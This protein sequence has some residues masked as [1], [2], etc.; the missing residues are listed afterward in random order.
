MRFDFEYKFHSAGQGLFSS[1]A[2]RERGA[3][4]P[5]QWVFDCGSTAAKSLLKPVV[6]DFKEQIENRIDLLCISHFD[7]D[8]VSGLSYLLPGIDVGTL[9]LPNVSRIERM[10]LGARAR[11]R[12]SDRPGRD[13]LE[14]LKDPAGFVLGRAESVERVI[15]VGSDPPGDGGAEFDS[16]PDSPPVVNAGV[17][18]VRASG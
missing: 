1:G 8:H 9:V 17:I 16:P 6:E 15:L 4:F 3:Q 13:Y 11:A 2:V 12:Y 7:Y 10:V 14:F 18:P 5:F